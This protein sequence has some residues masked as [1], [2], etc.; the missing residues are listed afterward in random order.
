[1]LTLPKLNDL[2]AIEGL[3]DRSIL[4]LCFLTK[5]CFNFIISK[6]VGHVSRFHNEASNDSG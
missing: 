3:K 5:L 1:M 2:A 6:F 4:T